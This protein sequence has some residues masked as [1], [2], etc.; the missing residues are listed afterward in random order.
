[1]VIEQKGQPRIRRWPMPNDR[2]REL[3]F[4]ILESYGRLNSFKNG[5][6]KEFNK[7]SWN[8]GD[9]KYDIRDWDE[10]HERMTKGITMWEHE[11]KELS[12]LLKAAGF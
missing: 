10:N 2:D 12:K 1:M 5:W 3:T 11:V 8:G 7:V 9:P 4:E 6:S